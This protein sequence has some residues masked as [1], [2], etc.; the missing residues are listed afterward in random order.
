MLV[1]RIEEALARQREQGGGAGGAGEV[2]GPSGGEPLPRTN[3]ASMGAPTHPEAP[4]VAATE[5]GKNE[6]GGSGT[7]DDRLIDEVFSAM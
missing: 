5:A 4:E 2:E 7:R 3:G 6:E 1:S